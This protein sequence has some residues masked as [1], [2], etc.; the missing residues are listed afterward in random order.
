LQY[1]DHRGGDDRFADA[2]LGGE[3]IGLG[4]GSS[5]GE[6]VNLRKFRKQTKKLQDTE[7]AAANRHAHGQSKSERDLNK[8]R[9][10][11]LHKHLDWH[12]IESGEA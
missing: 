9:T 10:E 5:M 6:I 2:V 7:R 3:Q 12:K 4:G 8:L 1:S 11:R